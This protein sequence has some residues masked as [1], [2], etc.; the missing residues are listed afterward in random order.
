MYYTLSI[1]FYN[2]SCVLPPRDINLSAAVFNR[3]TSEEDRNLVLKLLQQYP[4]R[5]FFMPGYPYHID[6]S[7]DGDG[8]EIVL[9]DY[10]I[11]FNQ[12]GNERQYV[13]ADRKPFAHG[14]F[15]HVYDAPLTL[16]VSPDSEALGVS[17]VVPRVLKMYQADEDGEQQAQTAFLMGQDVP[18][19]GLY[20]PVKAADTPMLVATKHKGI[21]LLEFLNRERRGDITLTVSQRCHLTRLILKTIDR[22]VTSQGLIHQDLQPENVLIDEAA[23]FAGEEYCMN[24]IDY[25]LSR[26]NLRHHDPKSRSGQF[27]FSAP[28]AIDPRRPT[29]EKADVYAA[30]LLLS[31]VWRDNL[32][33]FSFTADPQTHWSMD[34]AGYDKK[35]NSLR[36]KI[37]MVYHNRVR[38]FRYLCSGIEKLPPSFIS[39]LETWLLKVTQ[40][41]PSDRYDIIE[42]RLA[43]EIVVSEYEAYLQSHPEQDVIAPPKAELHFSHQCYNFSKEHMAQQERVQLT[44]LKKEHAYDFADVPPQQDQHRADGG[45]DIE[46]DSLNP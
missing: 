41:N 2:W 16:S 13:V 39:G 30:G 26:S 40:W 10:I 20:E 28:E 18:H 4:E 23:F 12:D 1:S 24:V 33:Q 11:Q 25:G 46:A 37:L 38:D 42:A 5:T 44:Y 45:E 22:Q 34:S 17:S 31:L 29:T 27:F 19:L 15:A 8:V 3:D 6:L 35:V 14:H 43:F 32:A 7:G 9:S 36:E 21:T